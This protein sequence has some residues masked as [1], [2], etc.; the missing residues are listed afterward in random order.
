VVKSTL[1]TK[2]N[3]PKHNVN[4]SLD[5]QSVTYLKAI[6]EALG[7]IGVSGAVRYCAI[8]QYRRQQARD[9]A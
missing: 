9:A 7:D 6:S 8:E 2:T 5:D 1:K 3:N 4:L